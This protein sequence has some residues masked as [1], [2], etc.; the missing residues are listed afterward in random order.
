[1]TLYKWLI[2]VQGN[3]AILDSLLSDLSSSEQ[4]TIV[5]DYDYSD[6]PHYY[7]SSICLNSLNDKSKVFT[8][9]K[10]K[11]ILF[12]GVC[13]LL[14]IGHEPFFFTSEPLINPYY[15]LNQE[16]LE[17]LESFDYKSNITLILDNIYRDND[18]HKI[19]RLLGKSHNNIIWD[20][21]YKIYE[22]LKK[23]WKEK[24]ENKYKTLNSKEW[25]IFTRTANH[26]L[27]SG[28]DARHG[29]SYN[30][31]PQKPIDII[32]ARK[33]IKYACQ[34]LTEKLFNLQIC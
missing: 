4:A 32:D 12:N 8:I 26:P 14:N 15:E 13:C 7:F 6:H 25:G 5:V 9:A 30:E 29:Y 27:V 28:D 24:D 33:K 1:M 34:E 18:Y 21:L 17:S 19:I 16:S 3:G 23:K 11:L 22:I 20:D 31:P 10:E 2:Y